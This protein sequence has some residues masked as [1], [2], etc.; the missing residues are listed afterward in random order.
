MADSGVEL[1]RGFAV[2]WAA[3]L[4]YYCSGSA[5]VV[6]NLAGEY[7]AVLLDGLDNMTALAVDP[8]RGKLYWALVQRGERVEVADGDAGNRRTLLD[9]VA[10]PLLKGITS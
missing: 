9:A 1:P 7:T 2:D 10:D 4:L 5:L 8:R 6:S 3:R